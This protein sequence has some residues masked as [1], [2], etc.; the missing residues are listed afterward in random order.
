MVFEGRETAWP[1]EDYFPHYF[2]TDP[3][4]QACLFDQQKCLMSNRNKLYCNM[5]YQTHTS[6]NYLYSCSGSLQDVM[7]NG[8]ASK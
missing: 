6:S 5:L 7:F 8:S 4:L 3:K 1:D 2:W